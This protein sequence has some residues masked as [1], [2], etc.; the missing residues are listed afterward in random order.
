LAV[1]WR[2]QLAEGDRAEPISY[3][4]QHCGHKQEGI[5]GTPSETEAGIDRLPAHFIHDSAGIPLAITLFVRKTPAPGCPEVRPYSANG[6]LCEDKSPA[7]RLLSPPH[8]VGHPAHALRE[9]GAGG[10]RFSRG[11]AQAL[12]AHVRSPGGRASAVFAHNLLCNGKRSGR[13][14]S[15]LHDR[16]SGTRP[17]RVHSSHF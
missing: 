5:C 14:R 8:S 4:R 16:A 6:C 7:L 15:S 17:C 11:D 1:G 2:V 13:R 10:P 9:P 12:P 3:G